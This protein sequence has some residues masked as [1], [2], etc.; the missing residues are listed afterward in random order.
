MATVYPS[1]FGPTFQWE[2]T[3]GQPAVGDKAFFY[4]AGSNTKINTYTNSTGNTA[5]TNPVILNALGMP[6]N[7]VWWTSGMLYKVVWA[8]STDTDPPTSPIR[9]WDNLSGIGDSAL[10]AVSEWVLFSGAATYINATSFSVTGDQTSIFQIGRRIQTTNAGGTVYSTITNSVFG[11]STVV[12][13][14][15]DSGVLDSGLSAVYYGILSVTNSSVPTS[16]A[17][18]AS[19]TFTG[20]PK[21]PTPSVGDDDTSIPTTAFVNQANKQIQS[22][23]ATVAANAL[24][25]TLNPT[26]LW[27]RSATATNGVPNIRGIPTAI[28]MVVSSG[29]TLGT[30]N[31]TAARIVLLAIDNAGTVELACVNLAGGN[32]LSET[33]F[34]TTVSEGGAGGADSV[35]VIYSTT[36]RTNVPY[37]VVGYIDITE[38]TAGTWATAPTAIQGYGGQALAAMSS[39]GYGQTIQDLTASRALGTTYF[40][41]TGKPI[42]VNLMLSNSAGGQIQPAFNGVNFPNVVLGGNSEF[43]F[44][45]PPGNSYKFTLTAGAATIFAWT[46]TR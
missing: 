19:P 2:N 22:I 9:T 21:A 25:L 32:D 14:V 16:I 7:E 24:T 30:T 44:V 23:A 3:S 28:S 6:P 36:A 10:V 17:R 18:I 40:N 13:V 8:P 37:R 4:L 29:S 26:T 35:N 5:N 46:E 43:V 34:I 33:G 20:D 38:A 31:A 12:T 11:A 15:N 1:A 39:L 41:L 27:F 45:I 42:Y